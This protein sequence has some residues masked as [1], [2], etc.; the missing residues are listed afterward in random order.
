MAK[1]MSP[2]VNAEPGP[3]VDAAWVLD[4]DDMAYRDGGDLLCYDRAWHHKFNRSL[5]CT[6][7]S[8]STLT[9]SHDGRW[10]V[11]GTG[12]GDLKVWDTSSWAVEATL[13]GAHRE[14]P[15]CIVIS[16]AQR[17]MVAVQHSVLQIFQCCPPWALEQALPSMVC[18]GND[19]VSEWICAAFAPGVEVDHDAGQTG[20]HNHLAVLSE[21]HLCDFE[22]SGGWNDDTPRRT[23]SL[24]R[25]ARP[26]GVAFTPCCRYIACTF[27]NGQMQIWNA[28]SLTIDRKVSAHIGSVN[29]V[30]SSPP[31][32]DYPCRLVTCGVD[33]SIRLWSSQGWVLEQLVPDRVCLAPDKARDEVGVT[34]CAFSACGNWLVS[35]AREFTIF[36]VCLNH[37][38][39]LR[40]RL[41]QR[42]EA[43]CS[44][45]GFRTAAVSSHRFSVAASSRDGV[46]GV[47]AKFHGLPA[48]PAR[49]GHS[50]AP[51]A[52]A[53]N[54]SNVSALIAP[55]PRPMRKVSSEVPAKTKMYVPPSGPDGW[56]QKWQLKSTTSA[57][58]NVYPRSG[59][60]R[61]S[62]TQFGLSKTMPGLNSKNQ[63]HGTSSMPDITRWRSRSFA[64]DAVMTGGSPRPRSWCNHVADLTFSQRDTYEPLSPK[65]R[66]RQNERSDV[67]RSM[68]A[69]GRLSSSD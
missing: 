62:G 54:T 50:P 19:E 18:P 2:A 31:L 27:S 7:S 61:P 53:E 14:P 36:R 30:I 12:S 4:C 15:L 16:P 68:S 44:A 59:S 63:M 55:L 17:W 69:S 49:L 38:G 42:V 33:Y 37:H 24:L 60:R 43:M 26:T 51:P 40:L 6:S 29:S 21:T 67:V 41:H 3:A 28:S 20:V 48:E 64:F 8:V 11:S 65:R 23:H 39:E 52:A 25:C 5:A 1:T 22:F 10:L 32:A 57:L 45:V 13:K 47:W 46:L 9:F 34:R 35:V 58:P 66:D 56:S